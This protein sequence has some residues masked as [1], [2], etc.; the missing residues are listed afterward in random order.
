MRSGG[1]RET[2]VKAGGTER[3]GANLEVEVVG[4]RKSTI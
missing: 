4:F 3:R 2:D 1:K